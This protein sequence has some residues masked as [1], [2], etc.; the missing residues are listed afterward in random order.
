MKTY[1]IQAPFKISVEESDLQPLSGHDVLVKVTNIGLCGSDLHLYDGKYNGPSRYPIQFG[2]EWAGIVESVGDEVS[3]F[4]PG[5]KVTGDCSRY[6]GHC[7]NCF[8]DRNLCK[9]IEKF[10]ITIDGASAEYIVRDRKYLY[11][12]DPTIDLKLLSLTEPIAVAKHMIEKIVSLTGNPSKKKI[13][14]YGAGPIGQSVLLMLTDLFGCTDVE[15]YDLQLYRLNFALMHGARKASLSDIDVTEKKD[16]ASLYQTAQY[17]MII[18]TTGSSNVLADAISLLKPFGILGCL[19]MAQTATIPQ[20][21]IVTKSLLIVGT[22]GGTGEFED[23]IEYIR[24]HPE[25]V[26]RLISHQFPIVEAEKA[27]AVALAG[28]D[29]MKVNLTL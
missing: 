23:V 1:K 11:K 16:Y 29:I 22:I 26:S 20:S 18:E 2:H 21:Q 19:G 14:I 7:E 17:D 4:Q 3:D 12:A 5:D 8:V 9:H 10:G 6:C 13:L 27:F 24:T 25:K 15:I 28:K